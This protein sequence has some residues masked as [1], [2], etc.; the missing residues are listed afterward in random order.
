LILRLLRRKR[1]AEFGAKTR[2]KCRWRRSR[3]AA[4]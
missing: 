2:T 4:V 1:V 3:A